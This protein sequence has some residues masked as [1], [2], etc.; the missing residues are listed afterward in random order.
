MKN[1]VNLSGDSP[2]YWLKRSVVAASEFVNG[3]MSEEEYIQRFVK[4]NG[5]GV[6]PLLLKYYP[7][8]LFLLITKLSLKSR[9]YFLFSV[10]G[11]SIPQLASNYGYGRNRIQKY[12]NVEQ[13]KNDAEFLARLAII[14]RI[15]PDWLEFEEPSG[16]WATYHF[17]SVDKKPRFIDE[18]IDVI[19]KRVNQ[20]PRINGYVVRTPSNSLLYVRI[21]KQYGNAMVEVF[22]QNVIPSDLVWFITHLKKYNC[23]YGKIAS[24]IPSY[25]NFCIICHL[26]KK[27][28][29]LP[30]GYEPILNISTL[31]G[32]NDN[33][34]N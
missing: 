26:T 21:E 20:A 11:L 15:P 2:S 31:L 8:T 27:T 28:F 9:R 25:I 17:H 14:H 29:C 33:I 12:L 18:L 6:N 13:E 7:K 19:E 32:T 16:D 34:N 10:S 24:M 1:K 23:E 30:S 5:G 22:N 4:D 3:K